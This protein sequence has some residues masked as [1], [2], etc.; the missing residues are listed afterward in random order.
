MT[1]S[2]F[3]LPEIMRENGLTIGLA[4]P[5]DVAHLSGLDIVEGMGTGTL[6]MPPMAGVLPIVPRSWSEGE[7]TFTATPEEHF[8]NPMGTVHGGWAMTM[9]DTAMAIACQ[10]TV[11]AG[12]TF[13]SMDTSVRFARPIRSAGEELTIVGRV[14]SKGRSVVVCNG[15]IKDG[16]GRLIASGSS[17]CMV[18]SARGTLSQR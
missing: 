12:Q 3:H 8:L 17:S 6:P 14:L 18:M 1:N 16:R 4:D 7:A 9:L 11:A 2:K 13:T 10:T 5:S 15:S